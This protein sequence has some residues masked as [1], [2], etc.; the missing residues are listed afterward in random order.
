MQATE[1]DARRG[2]ALPEGAYFNRSAFVIV[3]NLA[4]T[5]KE[6]RN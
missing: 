1:A 4:I 3:R 2:T 6:F 5:K